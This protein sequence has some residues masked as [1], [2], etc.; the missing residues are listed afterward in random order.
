MTCV[1]S[2]KPQSHRSVQSGGHSW[3]F[4]SCNFTLKMP[5]DTVRGRRSIEQYLVPCLKT[6]VSKW[7]YG[8][9]WGFT[10][11]QPPHAAKEASPKE[12]PLLRKQYPSRSQM[13]QISLQKQQL[14]SLASFIFPCFFRVNTGHRV[15]SVALIMLIIMQWISRS[16]K[17][18][19]TCCLLMQHYI[20]S[21]HMLL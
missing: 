1:F 20:I 12:Q 15:M 5:Q 14:F 18:R 10:D 9:I 13:G 21:S 3:S 19:L 11:W 6:E 16:I 7:R 8:F 17:Q 4:L 2:T